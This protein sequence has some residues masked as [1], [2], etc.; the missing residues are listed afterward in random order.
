[1]LGS[2]RESAAPRSQVPPE[3]GARGP[4]G[5]GL[6]RVVTCYPGFNREYDDEYDDDS[7]MHSIDLHA[8][9]TASDGSLT[10]TELVSLA[11]ET[12]LSALA[13]TDH[14]T[15]DGLA[16]AGEAAARH[17]IELVPGIELAVTYPNGR[18]HMLGYLIDPESAVLTNRLRLLKENRASRNAR[19]VARMQ[20]I[21]LPVTM[22]EVRDASG[23]GQI[24]RPHMALALVRKGLVG[25]V[26]EAF[27]RYLADGAAAHV[28]KDKITL[29][30]GID[31]I[32]AAEGVAV[33]AHPA[34][35]GL[36][37][38]ALVDELQRLRGLGLD[39]VECYYSQHTPQRTDQL[40]AMAAQAGLLPTGGSDFHGTPKPDV[41]LGR[42]YGDRP[43]P[44]ALLQALKRRKEERAAHHSRP[45]G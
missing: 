2:H 20:K 4:N 26:K 35:L 45:P 3:S 15:V 24:G 30:E 43:A 8:H 34:S 9:T 16:E 38:D 18:F 32:H 5:C 31:L 29:Q 13:V 1:M 40:L 7:D 36:T 39:G 33:M 19:M 27:D 21:G 10:P 14:D 25:S 23:G 11:A 37:D 6:P 22:E 12:G 41:F 44:D 17:G 42:V 28:P